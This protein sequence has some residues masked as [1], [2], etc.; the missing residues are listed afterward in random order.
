MRS[1]LPAWGISLLLLA[2]PA[3]A[4]NVLPARPEGV[5][6]TA[7]GV[8]ELV[9]REYLSLT[10]FAGYGGI[11]RPGHWTPVDVVVRARVPPE[12]RDLVG[13]TLEG[14][15]RVSVPTG[16]K[17][18]EEHV[19]ELA[20]PFQG[21]HRVSLLV[22]AEGDYVHVQFQPNLEGRVLHK[23][24]GTGTDRIEGRVRMRQATPDALLVAMLPANERPLRAAAGR[25]PTARM[26]P[27]ALHPDGVPAHAAHW[28]GLDAAVLSLTEV[29]RLPPS[30]QD[31]L[32]DW[33][34]AGGRLIL[35]ARGGAPRL[36][37][38]VKRILPAQLGLGRP[39]V[40]GAEVEAFGEAPLP[41][42]TH[43]FVMA[44]QVVP[45]G[46]VVVRVA[47]VP[48]ITRR[49]VGSGS[50][51]LVGAD[52][53]AP[54]F[55]NWEGSPTLWAKL[56]PRHAQRP[57]GGRGIRSA[58]RAAFLG[59]REI[60]VAGLSGVLVLFALYAGAIGPGLM[61]G[62]RRF[63]RVELYWP[64]VG[65]VV[66]VVVLLTLSTPAVL[67]MDTPSIQTVSLVHARSG[68]RV[69]R[70]ETYVGGTAHIAGSADLITVLRHGGVRVFGGVSERVVDRERVRRVEYDPFPV[71]RDVLVGPNDAGL[72]LGTAVFT[73][74]PALRFIHLGADRYVVRNES[75]HMLTG[76]V[77]VTPAGFALLESLSPGQSVTLAPE[78]DPRFRTW[79]EYENI[80]RYSGF[81]PGFVEIFPPALDVPGVLRPTL[82]YPEGARWF[83]ADPESPTLFAWWR[84]GATAA[85]DGANA[86][87]FLGDT[88]LVIT[89]EDA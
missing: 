16:L 61:W 84:A 63:E 76:P 62:L 44:E 31:G 50:V 18:S 82:S 8:N 32:L 22:L 27:V 5:T 77:I 65:L 47:G 36:S 21:E 30:V 78:A 1:R 6:F 66:S 10:V 12:T 45:R 58:V 52:L 74:T 70:L 43:A 11:Y 79:V 15:L 80:T 67:S 42:G 37:T 40:A 56:L 48:L 57:S 83:G 54:P 20:V 89:P 39:A 14:T 3:Q 86:P 59:F 64:A 9:A 81:L 85:G 28:F 51:T 24:A 46:E 13:E 17:A 4:Q 33:V 41:S 69:G 19:M 34:Y 2:A 23:L 60:S 26:Q 38:E 29:G 53:G 7:A 25:G 75:V 88:L 49:R 55:A 68:A 73:E 35:T 71:A 72:L 87:T